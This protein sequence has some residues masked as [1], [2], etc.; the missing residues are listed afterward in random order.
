M[1]LSHLIFYCLKDFSLVQASH[2]LF[3]C[4]LYC[5]WDNVFFL[6]GEY[7]LVVRHSISES[8]W[9]LHITRQWFPPNDC[10]YDIQVLVE[11]ATNPSKEKKKT[12][13]VTE[14][15]I[16]KSGR[17]NLTRKLTK[18]FQGW[19]CVCLTLIII[20]CEATTLSA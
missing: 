8:S 16:E 9:S 18:T 6:L 10:F 13:V 5:L 4:N 19:L 3:H 2:C 1:G 7:N 14:S 20:D 15:I 11:S 12:T 17:Y